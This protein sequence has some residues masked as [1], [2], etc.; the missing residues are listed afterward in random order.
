[1]KYAPSTPLRAAAPNAGVPIQFGDDGARRTEH[2]TWLRLGS[3]PGGELADKLTT[4]ASITH[5]QAS[6]PAWAAERHVCPEYRQ[7][8]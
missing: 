3:K 5:N 4:V 2:A 7:E 8:V 6:G 1:M